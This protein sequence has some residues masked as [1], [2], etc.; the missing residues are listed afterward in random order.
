MKTRHVKVIGLTYQNFAIEEKL[1]DFTQS[2]NLKRLEMFL[3]NENLQKKK[4]TLLLVNDGD[5]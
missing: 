3:S 2:S 4:C 5:I 1:D